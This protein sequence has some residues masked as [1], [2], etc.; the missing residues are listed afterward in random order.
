MSK[1]RGFQF[2]S[3][4]LATCLVVSCS[5][6]DPIPHPE[7]EAGPYENG[8]FILNEGWFGNEAGSVNFYAYG[9]DS[10][11]NN[12]YARENNGE[13]ASK[14]GSTL[15]NGLIYDGRLYMISKAG[16][17][18]VVASATTLKKIGVI[19]MD[20]SDFRSMAPMAPGFAFVST[21]KGILPVNLGSLKVDPTPIA[22]DGPVKDLFFSDGKLY[23]SAHKGVDIYNINN[24]EAGEVMKHYD[25]PTEGYVETPDKLVYGGSKKL[26]ITIDPATMDTTQIHLVAPINQNEFAYSKSSIVASRKENAVYYVAASDDFKPN[27]IYKYEKGKPNS[28]QKPFITLPEGEQFYQTGI[29]YDWVND[30][31]IT[32]S[33]TGYSATDTNF[34]R[35]YDAKTGALK[36]KIEYDH[37]YFPAMIVFRSTQFVIE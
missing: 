5:K 11:I 7:P 29:G 28:I 20:N 16:G 31:I 34:L 27:D 33:I 6:D 23:A 26:L 13:G 10:L 36:K 15:E 25:G 22:G 37:P 18:I 1:K 21:D 35:F 30:Q 24:M 12:A 2:L 9:T 3:L 32:I 14:E 17:D 4:I 8:F 19:Q